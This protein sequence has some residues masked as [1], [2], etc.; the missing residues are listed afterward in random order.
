VTAGSE[1]QGDREQQVVFLDVRG[2]PLA[3]PK[4]VSWLQL[5]AILQ[6][7]FPW[8]DLRTYEEIASAEE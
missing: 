6:L 2:G 5:A 1:P 7:R 8:G 4:V 3:R